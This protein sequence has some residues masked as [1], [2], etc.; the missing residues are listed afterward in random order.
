MSAAEGNSLGE[1]EVAVLR[2]KFY[3]HAQSLLKDYSGYDVIPESGKVVVFDSR[4]PVK[5]ALNGLLENKIKGAP[6]WDSKARRFTGMVTV[7]DFIEILRHL[8]EEGKND[9]TAVY[10]AETLEKQKIR[11]WAGTNMCFG[12]CSGG[13]GSVVYARMRFAVLAFFVFQ[14]GCCVFSFL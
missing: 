13:S 5:A 8:T 12:G 2:E 14:L 11:D 4:I 10:L 1:N 6:V 3:T 7:T 9:V